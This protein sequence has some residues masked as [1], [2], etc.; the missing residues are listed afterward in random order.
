MNQI[1]ISSQI[2]S[3][4]LSKDGMFGMPFLSNSVIDLQ[5]KQIQNNLGIFPILQAKK[6]TEIE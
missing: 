6:N 3:N 2:V 4:S 5:T 1:A